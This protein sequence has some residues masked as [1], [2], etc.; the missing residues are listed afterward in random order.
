[1]E[2]WGDSNSYGQVATT[3]RASMSTRIS[4][5]SWKRN[6]IAKSPRLKRINNS[7]RTSISSRSESMWRTSWWS[8]T[9]GTMIIY[10]ILFETCTSADRISDSEKSINPSRACNSELARRRWNDFSR[11]ERKFMITSCRSACRRTLQISLLR[12][13]FL[14]ALVTRNK[15][16]KVGSRIVS[17]HQRVI[18]ERPQAYSH[19]PKHECYIRVQICSFVVSST[20]IL[21]LVQHWMLSKTRAQSLCI[22]IQTRRAENFHGMWLKAWKKFG[23]IKRIKGLGKRS[24]ALDLKQTS[25]KKR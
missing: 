22:S 15:R 11:N 21:R 19:F 4:V 20:C 10:G 13:L 3:E 5:F 18:K 23:W 12:F 17:R 7:C 8:A 24:S 9:N 2:N 25:R 16:R 6:V 1:M 14:R